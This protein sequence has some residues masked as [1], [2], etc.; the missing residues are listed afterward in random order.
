[1]LTCFYH[2]DDGQN[3]GDDRTHSVEDTASSARAVV[4][5]ARRPSATA[6]S[7]RR[8]HARCSTG[9]GRQHGTRCTPIGVVCSAG[10]SSH[11][12]DAVDPRTH[13]VSTSR[14]CHDSILTSHQ[15]YGAPVSLW[16]GCV[17]GTGVDL[18]VELLVRDRD[19]TAAHVLSSWPR[20]RMA[21]AYETGGR[22]CRRRSWLSEF[23][24]RQRRRARSH[25]TACSVG[26]SGE[27]K[28]FAC[29][30]GWGAWCRTRV[31]CVR[32]E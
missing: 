16:H 12:A 32:G 7:T 22:V 13:N 3:G 11:S 2:A 9:P 21:R 6:H 17:R 19:T 26:R 25:S 14:E 15:A 4:P 23:W 31:R 30:V 10:A 20:S 8:T 5:A 1:M 28:P 18:D 27:R 24:R 29:G